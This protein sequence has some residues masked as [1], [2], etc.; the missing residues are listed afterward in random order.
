MRSGQKRKNKTLKK[1]VFTFFFLTTRVVFLRPCMS[2][3]N[4]VADSD[5]VTVS[6]SHTISTTRLTVSCHH[7]FTA[8]LP[9]GTLHAAAR[10]NSRVFARM[11][12]GLSGRGGGAPAACAPDQPTS[13]AVPS[14]AANLQ[15]GAASK[16]RASTAGR[17]RRCR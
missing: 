2:T 7:C 15:L 8:L 10:S 1:C 14:P 13:P 5:Y 3:K 4:M 16:D 17:H 9:T 11:S 6:L 12:T